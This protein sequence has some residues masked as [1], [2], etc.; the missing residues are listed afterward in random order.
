MTQKQN[1]AKKQYDYKGLWTPEP[2]RLTKMSRKDLLK[3]VNSIRKKWEH[4]TG[5]SQQLDSFII[6]DW[7]D[8]ELIDTIRFYSSKETKETARNG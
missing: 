7:K 5:V 2:K 6:K 1:K 8:K 3:K 4:F